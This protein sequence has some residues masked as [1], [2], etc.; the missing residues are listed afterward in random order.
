MNALARV[1]GFKGKFVQSMISAGAN[2]VNGF[3]KYI[4]QLPGIVLGEF[5]RVLGLVNDFINTLPDRVWDMG[6]AIIDALKK[7]LG[8]GSPGHMFYMIQGEFDRIDNLTQKTRFDTGSIG[9]DMVSS[10]NPNLNAGSSGVLSGSAIGGDTIINVY[11]DVDSDKRVREIVE[12]V[13]RELSF[14]NETAGRTV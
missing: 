9:A 7:S 14:N 6:A 8:I 2:A 12:A 11:G 10:F 13:R 5:N 1:L 3:I 4:T